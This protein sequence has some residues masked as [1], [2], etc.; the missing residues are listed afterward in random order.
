[1]DG[2]AKKSQKSMRELKGGWA[3]TQDHKGEHFEQEVI[4]NIAF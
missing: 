3:V 4:S 2:Q 1:M